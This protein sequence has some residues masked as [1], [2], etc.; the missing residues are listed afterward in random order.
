[1]VFSVGFWLIGMAN[2]IYLP[3]VELEEELTKLDAGYR[4]KA[5][6][7]DVALSGMLV[8]NLADVKSADGSTVASSPL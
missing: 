8:E 4:A 5:E 3:Y 7:G 6:Y 1:M 2:I